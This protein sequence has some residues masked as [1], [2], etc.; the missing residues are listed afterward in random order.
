MTF[1]A[2]VT[3]FAMFSCKGGQGEGH[4][5]ARMGGRAGDAQQGWG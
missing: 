1:M 5:L 3:G 2:P 4:A